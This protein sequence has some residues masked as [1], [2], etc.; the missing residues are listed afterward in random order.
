MKYQ[1]IIFDCDG[2]LVDS[3][4]ISAK[5][6]AGIM[7][8][9]G[10]DITWEVVFKT[11]KGGSMAKSIAFVEKQLGG[12]APLDIEKTYRAR[13]KIAFQKE[14]KP[15]EGIEHVLGDLN[16][17]FCVGSNGP[18]SKIRLNLALS[19]LDHFFKDDHIFSAYD[20]EEWKPKPGLFLH[21]AEQMNFDPAQ[22]VVIEDSV[23]GAI[24]A[25]AAGIDCFGYARDSDPELFTSHNA[26]PFHDMKD[27]IHI[28]SNQS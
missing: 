8:D 19:K 14:M 11:L 20:I 28:L 5:V 12:P 16:I 15:I 22:C 24:A 18:Q 21:A 2:V 17:P 27:L 6:F 25:K 4:P 7:N 23:N 10:I 26:V 3:E 13:T 9:L 1:C